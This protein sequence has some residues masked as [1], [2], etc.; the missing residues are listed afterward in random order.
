MRKG[1]DNSTRSLPLDGKDYTVID[2][3]LVLTAHAF[4]TTTDRLKADLVAQ[5]TIWSSA[6]GLT[7][8]LLWQEYSGQTNHIR[9]GM[10][11]PD[12]KRKCKNLLAAQQDVPS[13]ATMAERVLAEIHLMKA[14]GARLGAGFQD[15]SDAQLKDVATCLRA[16][17]AMAPERLAPMGQLR[18]ALKIQI[19]MK[20][21]DIAR[22]KLGRKKKQV[23]EQRDRHIAAIFVVLGL[24]PSTFKD[25][26]PIVQSGFVRYFSTTKPGAS[27]IYD[28]IRTMIATAATQIEVWIKKLSIDPELYGKTLSELNAIIPER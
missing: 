28:N 12:F 10:T 7:I 4:G 26:A 5:D 9:E 16:K 22:V 24:S 8:R 14:E 13:M 20:N 6:V 27:V 25:A 23:D 3:I 18:K 11:K 21:T 2:H 15:L 19:D 17:R 1:E